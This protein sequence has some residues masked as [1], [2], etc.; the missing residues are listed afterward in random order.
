MI[1][2][3]FD[4]YHDQIRTPGKEPVV[5]F[6][7]GMVSAFGF[8]R[9]STRMIRARVSWWPGNI[10]RG[11]LHLHHEIFGIVLML[12]SGGLSF[13]VRTVFPWRELL[14]LLFGIG[15]GLVLDEFALLLYLRDVYWNE[16]GRT[17]LDAVLISVVATVMVLVSA[18]PFGFNDISDGETR[19][20]WVAVGIVTLNLSL[21]VVTALK[22]KLWTALVSVAVPPVGVIGCVRL[23]APS[24]PWARW[25]YHDKPQRQA[26]AQQRHERIQRL[27]NAA[28]DAIGGKPI[29]ARHRT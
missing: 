8:I 20:R 6:L 18:V 17:S 19:A 11:G 3:M 2:W 21:T 10:E 25:H 12:V 15:A 7:L 4:H 1:G 28:L 27:R 26:T 29:H 13:A 22:G 24:S 14:A 9:L 23:A 5:L 16:E